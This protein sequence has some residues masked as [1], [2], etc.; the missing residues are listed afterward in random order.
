MRRSFAGSKHKMLAVPLSEVFVGN[1]G[2]KLEKIHRKGSTAGCLDELSGVKRW[3]SG[4]LVNF[5]GE[6][7]RP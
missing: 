6:K 1:G 3:I 5:G 2:A 4:P 7:N